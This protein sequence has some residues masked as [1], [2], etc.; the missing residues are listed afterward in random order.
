MDNPL[1]LMQDIH[2]TYGAVKALDGVTLTVGHG[3]VLGLVGDNAAGKSTL[4]KILSGAVKPDT[5]D[6]FFD[7]ERVTYE[8][9]SEARK[10]GIEMVYQ[11]FALAP[12]LDVVANMFLGREKAGALGVLKSNEMKT[13]AREAISRLNM[14]VGDF[15]VPAKKLSGGQQQAV[16]ISRAILFK[17]KLVIMDEPAASLSISVIVKLLDTIRTMKAHGISVILISHRLRDILEV[18]DRLVVLRAGRHIAEKQ[19]SDTNL[20]EVVALMMGVGGDKAP[21]SRPIVTD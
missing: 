13:M 11:D 21:P 14:N 15:S 20:E 2:K 6:I 4:M 8:T 18:S 5:G 17:P 9:P 7:G 1:V 3:E 16:A 12:N 10:R 19:I